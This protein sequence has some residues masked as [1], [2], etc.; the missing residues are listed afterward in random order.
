MLILQGVYRLLPWKTL[1]EASF[2]CT[3]SQRF[4]CSS[5][6]ACFCLAPFLNWKSFAYAC[7]QTCHPL[8]SHSELKLLYY[9]PSKNKDTG[10]HVV[11]NLHPPLFKKPLWYSLVF[12]SYPFSKRFQF[13]WSDWRPCRLFSGH[14]TRKHES[15]LWNMVDKVITVDGR[16]PAP[17]GIYKLCIWIVVETTNLNWCRICSINR[18]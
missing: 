7:Q 3:S 12:L 6:L 15:G 2:R 17:P 9:I 8:K 18:I 16:N 14:I 5:L 4:C 10:N 1:A 11:S 13:H